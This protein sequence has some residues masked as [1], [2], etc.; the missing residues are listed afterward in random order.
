MAASLPRDADDRNG[1]WY[2][3][4]TR[5]Q[6]LVLLIA[7]LGWIFD[8]FEG[9]IFVASMAEAMP[10]LTGATDPGAIAWYNNVALAA[11]SLGG[12][13]GGVAFGMLSDRIGRK[14]TLSL[15]ILFYSLFTCFSAFSQ[16]WR[17]L[18]AFRFLVALGVGGEWAVASSLV[19]EVFPTRARAHVGSIF[20][21]SS[22]LGSYLAVAAGFL[23]IGNPVIHAWAAESSPAWLS[24]YVDP[25]TLPWRLGYLV[26]VLP[27]MLVI[28]V[29]A[30]LKEPESW[31]AA[32][33]RASD[34]PAERAGSIADLF[35]SPLRRSTL[36]GVGLAT[37]GIVTFWTVYIYGKD[38]LRGAAEQQYLVAAN[39]DPGALSDEARKAALAPHAAAIKRQEMLGMFLVTTGGGLG[40]LAFGPISERLGRRGAFLLFH[41]GGLASSLVV[42]QLLYESTQ[43][44]VAL[45]IFGFLTL[46][47]H[48]GYAIYFPE[49]YPTRLRATGAGSCFNAGR[50]LTAP[51]L[52]MI[53]WMQS[54]LG[55]TQRDAISLLSLTFLAG[56][57]ILIYA[58]ETKGH[59][60]PE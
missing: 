46:G 4:V 53:G 29:R 15:T 34:D 54:S 14:K 21:G 23:I 41:L 60:L 17:H 31:Q 51:A 16:D 8:V 20:H 44:L 33:A 35:R 55:Y 1:R 27:A 3:G 40:L 47:M 5:Y 50:V 10:S 42:F 12:A 59:E 7:S 13:I 9:Q 36:V 2:D 11:F 37:V 45:P 26:G 25:A 24:E 28:W 6:W 49:L 19:A 22:V 52:L 48:A 32:Q 30:S 39:L 18:V 57:A 58:P 56:A 43:L 38:T